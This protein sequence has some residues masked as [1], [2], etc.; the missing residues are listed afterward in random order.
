VV[1]GKSIDERYIMLQT[2]VGDRCECAIAGDNGHGRLSV[3]IAGSIA[4]EVVARGGDREWTNSV[5]CAVDD[6]VDS[7][8]VDVG[9]E[10]GRGARW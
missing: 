3:I 1:E 5:T 6:G 4:V 2:T 9:L 7:S 8:V 10:A